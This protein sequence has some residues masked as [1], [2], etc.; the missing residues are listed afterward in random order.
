MTYCNFETLDQRKARAIAASEANQQLAG[1]FDR[2]CLASGVPW[3]EVVGFGRQSQTVAARRAFAAL[4][5]ELPTTYLGGS[6]PSFPEIARQIGVRN[7]STVITG[8][9]AVYTDPIA[10]KIVADVCDSLWVPEEDR[11]AWLTLLPLEN[12][13]ALGEVSNVAQVQDA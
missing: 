8:Y 6:R 11:P 9:R 4:A 2:V 3:T 10:K 12:R 1:L 13:R 5:R 7:H